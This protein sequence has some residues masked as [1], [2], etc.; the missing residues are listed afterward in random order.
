MTANGN[1]PR[2]NGRPGHYEVYYL[3]LTDPAT[4]VGVWVRYTML[5]PLDGRQATCALWLAVMDP[6]PG[7]RPVL[8]RKET[9]PIDQFEPRADPFEL[10]IATSVL[11]DGSMTGEFEGAAWELRWEPA[12]R[13]REPVAPWLHSVGLAHTALVLPQADARIDG[14]VSV[15]E[16]RL[17]ITGAR[18]GQAHLW[19]SKHATSWAWAH[20]ND[21]T[22]PD[23]E[24]AGDLFFDGVS[25]VVRRLGRRLRP[26]TPMVGR[27]AGRE[28]NSTSPARILSNRSRFGLDGWRFTAI[29]SRH[30]LVGE[31][32]PT[33]DQLVGVTYEDPDGEEAYCYNSETASVH[34]ELYERSRRTT[35]WRAS[36]T[37]LAVGRCHFEYGQRTPVAGVELLVK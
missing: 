22:A 2:W 11:T 12:P 21:L 10:R 7:A 35:G 13:A 23:G 31:V 1:H 20:C 14:W 32:R 18:G 5:A 26:S 33:R 4:G 6:R 17:E 27:V 16:E 25:A 19:G 30:K 36:G 29:D 24:P 9:F 3:T 34:L 37:F 8:A 28:F 15:G